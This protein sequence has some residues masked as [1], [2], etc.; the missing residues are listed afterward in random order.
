[1]V[2]QDR[3]RDPFERFELPQQEVSRPRV[4]ALLRDLE[5]LKLKPLGQGERPDVVERPGD[6]RFPPP[7]GGPLQFL[8]ETHREV[9]DPQAMAPESRVHEVERLHQG[10][11]EV[12]EV[13]RNVPKQHVFPR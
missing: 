11:D 3:L 10:G 4:G 8:R 2:V 6:R 1:V 13:D 5:F 7:P 9:G 12:P